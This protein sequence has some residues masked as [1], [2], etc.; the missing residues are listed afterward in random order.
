MASSTLKQTEIEFT[1]ANASTGSIS[2]SNSNKLSVSREMEFPHGLATTGITVNGTG[3]ITTTSDFQDLTART[4]NLKDESGDKITLTTDAAITSPYTLTLPGSQGSSNSVV[5]N[6]GSG[7][8]SWNYTGALLPKRWEF[9]RQRFKWEVGMATTGFTFAGEAAVS[10]ST[11]DHSIQ[12]TPATNDKFGRFY[13]DFGTAPSITDWEMQIVLKSGLAGADGFHV[14]ANSTISNAFFTSNANYKMTNL[15][16]VSS[17][18]GHMLFINEHDTANN[19][20]VKLY[21][22][23]SNIA[24]QV[25]KPTDLNNGYPQK[26]S[27]RKI[28]TTLTVQ[29]LDYGGSKCGRF[30]Y[31]G[32][33][34]STPNGRYWGVAAFTGASNTYHKIYSIE[35]RSLDQDSDLS[36]E[37]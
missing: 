15:S 23:S 6:N 10:T 2:F 27:F 20:F 1:N 3:A 14:F 4:F 31:Q 17:S 34:T 32:T 16:G 8:L 19:Y 24:T 30:L 9:G 25:A 26:I 21:D 12:L 7:A 33:T 29:L 36:T 11:E 18:G 13:Y 35:V 22:G 37:S 28:G 5:V